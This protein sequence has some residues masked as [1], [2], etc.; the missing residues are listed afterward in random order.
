MRPQC[1]LARAFAT[2]YFGDCAAHLREAQ[3]VYEQLA[4][5][6]KQDSLAL[7]PDDTIREVFSRSPKI[8]VDRLYSL[9]RANLQPVEKC[10]TY[11]ELVTHALTALGAEPALASLLGPVRPDSRWDPETVWVRSVRGI[12]N[13]R[14][15]HGGGCTC[16]P[17]SVG[18]Q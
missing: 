6:A 1:K 18:Q 4:A 9:V 8:I 11:G 2:S 3:A 17:I 13:E 12:V 10:R 14:V 5:L 7:D 15:R 16:A